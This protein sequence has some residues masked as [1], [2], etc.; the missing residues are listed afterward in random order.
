M[1]H[2]INSLPADLS[3][4]RLQRL[5]EGLGLSAT[6]NAEIGR[7]WFIQVAERRHERAYEPL[8][9]YLNRYGRGRLVRP[10]YQALAGNGSD[11]ALAQ[12]M[13]GRARASY[14]PLVEAS[15]ARVL[16]LGES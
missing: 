7:T 10:I 11:L 2:F 13:F 15:V 4:D 3:D 16:A 9:T 5:D 14:H 1:V 6:R 8:A 12:D